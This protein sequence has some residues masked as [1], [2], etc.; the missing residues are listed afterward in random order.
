MRVVGLGEVLWD[1]LP[2]GKQMAAL[3]QFCVSR[4]D[5]RRRSLAVSSVGMIR[6]G[7]DFGIICQHANL[8]GRWRL[9]RWRR[10]GRLPSAIS[11]MDSPV[12][13]P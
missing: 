3:G 8:R 9:I 13:H 6:S 7:G 11:P 10:Q 12:C 5:T 1:M 2:G 4:Q